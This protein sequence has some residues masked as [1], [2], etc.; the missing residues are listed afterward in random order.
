MTDS[1]LGRRLRRPRLAVAAALLLAAACAA[2]DSAP[3][4][5]PPAAC[6]TTPPAAVA[7]YYAA[8]TN[9]CGAALLQTLHTTIRDQRLLD[10]TTARDSLYAFVDRGDRT[11]IIDIYTGREV[12]Q[13]T[14]RAT[15]AANSINTE[16]LWPRSRGAELEPALSDLH[17]LFSSDETANSQRSNYPFGRVN[18]TVLWQSTAP[19]GQ[20]TE[21]S[22]L[23]Y[24]TGT[25]GPIVFEPR[26]S[27]RGD[28]ARALLYFYVRYNAARPAGYSLTNFAAERAFLLQWHAQDPVDE[29]ERTRNAN[30]FRAQGNRNPFIDWPELVTLIGTFPLN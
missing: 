19:A 5:G 25:S 27:V 8:T 20:P 16:H 2:G 7:T 30:V 11:A 23:G 10:Y 9:R 15:A 26:P 13:V 4:S 14:T 12:P 1:I 6:T 28:I 21:V 3:I 17:H 29:Y 18:G 24:A 22:R